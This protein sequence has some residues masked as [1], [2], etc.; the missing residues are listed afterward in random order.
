MR[1]VLLIIVASGIAFGEEEKE[2]AKPTPSKPI[3]VLDIANTEDGTY[4]G[5]ATPKEGKWKVDKEAGKIKVA[6]EPLDRAWLEFGP[7]I[8][9]KGAT[10]IATGRAEGTGRIR[11]RFGAGLYGENGFQIEA[12][13]AT[14]EVE[15]IRRGAVLTKV[16]FPI[17]VANGYSLELSVIAE[18]ENWQVSG[19]AWEEEEDRPE[20]TLFSFKMFAEELLFPL[21]GRPVLTATP[22]AGEPVIF[23]SA[24]VYDGIFVPE[25]E[26]EQES[27]EEESEK[28]EPKDDE[29]QEDDE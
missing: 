5:G 21:A 15:L 9:E 6:P 24:K 18:D 23:A 17:E 8:R 14:G 27:E 11:S 12:V 7:E 13:P 22:F 25:P 29:D 26:S 2:K 10:I 1:A 28:T 4:P 20:K 3:A 19:R 16:K